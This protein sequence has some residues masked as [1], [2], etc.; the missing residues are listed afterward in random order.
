VVSVCSVVNLFC[1]FSAISACSEVYL[2]KMDP[3]HSL[4]QSQYLNSSGDST[5]LFQTI[6]S[7]TNGISLDQALAY[8]EQ[9]VIEKR[10]AWLGA[11]LARLE[12]IGNP[13]M[14]G[15]HVFYETYL[16]ISIPVDG[17][18]IEQREHR[19]VMR[20]WNPC[21]TLAACQQLGL[22][23]REICKKAYHR[24]VQEFLARLDPNLRFDRN[25]QALRPYTPYC[26]EI[27]TWISPQGS[28]KLKSLENI[29]PG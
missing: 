1:F 13:V 12:R 22:D 5:R 24:P 16:G 3:Y 21:P 15:Y 11:N 4:I 25:Y 19:M 9:C 6:L 8:L 17:E 10:L 23:T 20:W 29:W 28:L 14:D 7:L 18:I 2:Y 27:I 26:E